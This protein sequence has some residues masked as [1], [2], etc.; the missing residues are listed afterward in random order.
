MESRHTNIEMF[1]GDNKQSFRK[2]IQIFTAQ[3]E[4]W[5]L[6]KQPIFLHR[7]PEAAPPE[8]FLGKGV[9]KQCSKFTGEHPCRCLISIKVALQ[10]CLCANKV[11]T[12]VFQYMAFS[13]NAAFTDVKEAMMEELWR[14]LQA[15]VKNKTANK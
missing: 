14:R 2:W 9:L 10:L 6:Q 13:N 4:E 11:F 8:L 15:N 3:L 5:D 7:Y 12:F 1:G